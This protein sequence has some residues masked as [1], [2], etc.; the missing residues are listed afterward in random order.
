[1]RGR[2]S[3]KRISKKDMSFK[4]ILK[5]FLEILTDSQNIFELKSQIKINSN[6]MTEE[7]VANIEIL[8]QIKSKSIFNGH[9]TNLSK[10]SFPITQESFNK[11]FKI[12]ILSFTNTI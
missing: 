4:I 9:S 3:T 7:K 6:S 12:I 8:G 2:S 10:V 11:I 5:I 1:M